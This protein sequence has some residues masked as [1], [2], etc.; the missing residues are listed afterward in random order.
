MDFEKLIHYILNRKGLSTI[1]EINNS[2]NKIGENIDVSTQSLLEQRLKLNPEVFVE[3]NREYLQIF[4]K[5]YKDT[6]VKTYK[7][8]ILKPIDGSDFEIP[9]TKKSRDEFGRVQAIA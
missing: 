1:M 4:Y 5:K 9:N 7:G 8:Y 2:F 6:D 3:L